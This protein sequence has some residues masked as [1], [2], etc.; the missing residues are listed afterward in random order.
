MSRYQL[1]L[2]SGPVSKLIGKI[3]I[4]ASIG[5]LFNTLYSLVDAFFAGTLSTEALSALSV[6]FPLFFIVA[7]AGNGM[8]VGV[9][10]LVAN[11]VGAKDPA[12]IKRYIAQIFSFSLLFSCVVVSIAWFAADPLFRLL[13]A[14]GD[15]LDMALSYMRVVLL[16]MFILLV[17]NLANAVL[18]AHGDSK[19]FRNYLVCSALANV[20][21]DPWFIYGGFGVPAMGFEGIAWATVVTMGVGGLYMITQT[22]RRHMLSHIT[23]SDLLPN[24]SVYMQFLRQGVP[25]CMNMMTIAL[26]FFVVTYYLGMVGSVAVA[27]FGIA[28]RIEMFA[29]LPTI[30]LNI[31]ALAII[32]QNHGAQSYDR[33]LEAMRLCIRYGLII[34]SCGATIYFLFATPLVSFFTDDESV[35]AVGSGYLRIMA[36]ASWS[37]VIIG[38]CSVSL[39]AMRRPLSAFYINVIRQFVLPFIVLYVVVTFFNFGTTGIWWTIFTINW[40]VVVFIV[41]YTHQLI[42]ARRSHILN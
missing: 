21:L 4:P 30:G 40:C 33:I 15:Y 39:Q 36:L 37:Y 9:S 32:S 8:S 12:L 2:T 3:A 41:W 17:A 5:F 42:R 28:S 27:G 6:S 7:A 13:G 11:A 14:T 1:D 26:G 10:A 29:L 20:I 24:A 34:V 18:I 23:L 38:I 31:A 19:T 35:I 16:G 25:T 22:V